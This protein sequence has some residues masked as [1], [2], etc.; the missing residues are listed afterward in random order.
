[1][2]HSILKYMLPAVAAAV[3]PFCAVNGAEVDKAKAQQAQ[4]EAE[5]K[6]K[7]AAEARAKAEAEKKAAAAAAREEAKKKAAEE[8]RLYREYASALN[9]SCWKILGDK[10]MKFHEKLAAFHEHLKDPRAKQHNVFLIYSRMLGLFSG[11]AEVQLQTQYGYDKFNAILE[12]T[13]KEII[14]D[15]RI[16]NEQR[17]MAWQRLVEHYCGREMFAEAEKCARTAVAYP[18]LSDK[19][20]A[21]ALLILAEVYR[22]QDDLDKCIATVREAMKYMPAQAAAY[23]ARV[24]WQFN[25]IDLAAKIWK[26][27]NKPVDELIF[28]SGKSGNGYYST[29]YYRNKDDRSK[30]ARAFVK[31]TKNSIADRLNVARAYCFSDMDPENVA[32]RATLKGGIFKENPK[33]F[34]GTD[35]RLITFA[36]QYGDYPLIV[37]ICEI[38]EGSR[39]MNDLKVRKLHIVSLG[40]CGRNAEAVKYAEEYAKDETLKPVDRARLLILAAILGGKD[41]D[42]VVKAAGLTRKDESLVYLTAARYCLVWGK[43]DLAEKFTKK[44]QEYFIPHKLRVMKVAY[45]ET[46]VTMNVWRQNLP[47]LDKQLC[48]IPYQVNDAFL[49]ADV[50]TGDRDLSIDKDAADLSLIEISAM[51][52]RRGLHIFMRSP[53]DN[54]QSIRRGFGRGVSAEMYFAP[55]F[56]QSYTV[57][58][59]EPG[60]AVTYVFP[61]TYNNKM[62]TRLDKKDPQYN[63]HSEEEFTEKDYVLHLFFGFDAQYNRLP[64]NGSDWR[65]EVIT[66][67]PNGKRFCWGGSRSVHQA[68]MWG[69]MRFELTEKQLNDIRREIIFK[70]YKGYQNITVE[71]GVSR[72]LFRHWEDEELGDP[73]FAKTCLAP[74]EQKLKE[75]AAL[76]KE[77]MSDED[78]KKVYVNALPLWKGL[79][80]EIDELRRK[81]LKEQYLK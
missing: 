16:S 52:D 62:H 2:K 8:A 47:K 42:A 28:Y 35:A 63:F 69:S 39:T 56:N 38:I 4:A 17:L 81:Y 23:G 44:Y 30:D 49:I 51:A 26:E 22:F 55:G 79:P 80:H 1:M 72:N 74:L 61:C 3:L 50:A 7:A 19:G 76:V 25:K 34:S 65:Y 21:D 75:Y 15:T 77:D 20:K 70:A 67:Q 78:V 45:S 58:G 10:K 46:P 24:A 68:M 53:A 59:Y 13:T 48:D 5:A 18:D 57:L 60:K 29:N 37:D 66:R 27:A 36:S 32:A 11:S 73:E 6:K 40:Y 31:D 54:A 9:N 71:P 33:L 41:P 43:S 64:E 12:Q 14:N